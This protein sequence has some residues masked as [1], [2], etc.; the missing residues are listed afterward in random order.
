[1]STAES[2]PEKPSASGG[3]RRFRL[4]GLRNNLLFFSV[5]LALVP[6]GIAG[7]QMTRMTRDELKS[8]ANDEIV[9]MIAVETMEAVQNLD[10]ILEVEG[11]DGVFIGPVDLASSMFD[12]LAN[13][14]IVVEKRMVLLSEPIKAIGSYKVPIRVYKEVE[15]EITVEIV[16]E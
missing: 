8:S 16:P 4:L 15:P 2:S 11:L 1:M 9:V 5:L 10:G 3:G 14:D 7:L 6:L 12:T 13:Q